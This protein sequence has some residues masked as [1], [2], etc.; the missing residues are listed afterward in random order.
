MGSVYAA[1]SPLI[2]L[3]ETLYL[4]AR[5]N[6]GKPLVLPNADERAVYVI[7]GSLT[8]GDS[9]VTERS[10]AIFDDQPGVSVTADND[11]MIVLIGGAP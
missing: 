8:V 6:A 2:T 7:S 11:A 10:M 5:L 3:S 1:T 9:Q 4:E